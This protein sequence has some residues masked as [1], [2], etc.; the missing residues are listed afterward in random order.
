[1]KETWA[2]AF[3]KL[4]EHEGGFTSDPRDPGNKLPDGRP[5]STNLGVTQKVWEDYVGQQVTHEEMKALTK[6]DVEPL[7]KKQYWDSIR[8]DLLPRGVD[9][10]VFDM[11]VNS[12][13]GRAAMTLQSCIGVKADGI[14]GPA[15]LA[16]VSNANLH[17]LIESFSEKRL[18]FMEKLPEWPIYGNGWER[19]V[20][21]VA[22]LA[23]N[24]TQ[25]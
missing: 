20:N 23:E 25:A 2:M 10:V 12:G 14:I 7:Y 13:P 9:Y 1:M 4:I 22:E 24:L 19:R 3:K 17:E 21:E 8:G 6:A 11:S 5:G 15:T 16:A 18:E